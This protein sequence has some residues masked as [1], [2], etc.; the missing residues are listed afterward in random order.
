MRSRLALALALT[1]ALAAI[2]APAAADELHYETFRFGQRAHGMGGAVVALPGEPEATIYNPAG[3]SL[4]GAGQFS[5]ALQ[6]YGIDRRTLR[7]SFRAGDWFEPLDE[8]SD[9]FLA[10]PSSSVIA[11]PVGDDGAH[12]FAFSTFLVDRTVEAFSGAHAQPLEE[13]GFEEIR[14]TSSRSLDDQIVY[15]GGSWSWRLNPDLSLGLSVFYARRD[16]RRSQQKSEVLTSI[17]EQDQQTNRFLT[18]TNSASINDG[19]L[20][21]R[22]GAYWKPAKSVALGLACS[23]Q[24]IRLHGK[25]E[26]GFGITYSGE[27]D[28]PQEFPPVLFNEVEKDIEAETVYPWNCRAGVAWQ[29]SP[30]LLLSTD[31]SV[32]LPNQYTRLNIDPDTRDIFNI[33]SQVVNEFESELLVNGAVGME[34][35]PTPRWP[36]RA[37]F[38]TNRSGAPDIAASPRA[39]AL[40][41]VHLY[42]AT[43]S[44]G[45][46]GDSRSI[47]LGAEVQWGQGDEV[48]VRELG[49]LISEPTFLRVDREQ[50]RFLFFVSGAFEFAKAT[51]MDLIKDEDAK[52]GEVKGGEEAPKAEPAPRVTDPAP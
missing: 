21:A 19:A 34:L 22:L 46:V 40:P 3:L 27:P 39:Y 4:L 1:S 20:L 41:Q 9:A 43:V 28:Q 42:G 8:K 23:T 11:K 51:A 18:V 29:A 6:F 15:I 37:G 30:W 45:Y 32:Y 31:V 44:T 25:A 50:F 13:A 35:R 36:I 16:E 47:N 10:L 26:L 14:Y 38:F 12:V 52:D 2:T 5:G 33:D 48:I 17:D 24:S 7:R 49:D